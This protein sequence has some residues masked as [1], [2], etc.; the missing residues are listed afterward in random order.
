MELSDHERRQL[1]V[2]FHK[3]TSGNAAGFDYALWVGF[4]DGWREFR[5][6]L[7]ERGYVRMVGAHRLAQATERTEELCAA[8]RRMERAEASDDTAADT[9]MTAAE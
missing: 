4:G 1:L 7:A 8:L 3:L 6:Q 2:G 5:E 9:P